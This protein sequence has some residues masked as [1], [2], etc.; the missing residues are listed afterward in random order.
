MSE[1]RTMQDAYMD[2]GG[3]VKQEA[4]AEDAKAGLFNA[5]TE[6]FNRCA[7]IHELIKSSLNKPKFFLSA[8]ALFHP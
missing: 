6:H 2:I 7:A 4:R 5:E 1:D 3:R 8:N